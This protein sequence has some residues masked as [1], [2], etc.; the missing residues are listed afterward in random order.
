M[1]FANLPGCQQLVLGTTI[2]SDSD[3]LRDL[4]GL[5][6]SLF[7]TWHWQADTCSRN[8]AV[9]GNL[10]LSIASKPC[11]SREFTNELAY[12]MKL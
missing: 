7:G 1:D 5:H 10:I 4:D 6:G 8:S 2:L 9:A 3:V 11:S 12:L